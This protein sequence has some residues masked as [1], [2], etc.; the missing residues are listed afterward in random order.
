[1][2]DFINFNE[3]EVLEGAIEKYEAATNTKLY[4]GDERRIIL[5][6]FMYIASIIAA[7]SNFLANQYYS[8]T[9]VFPY[10]QYIGEDKDVPIL[11]AE[12]SLVTMRFTIAAALLF[13]IEI[14][15]GTRVTPDGVHFFVTL[16]TK[17]ILQGNLSVD[18]IAEATVVG[19]GHNGFTPG[20]I[21][22]LVDNISYI[23]SVTNTDTSSGGS[24]TE[25]IEAYRER[26]QLKPF[27]YNTAGSEDAYIYLTKSTDNTIGSVSVS[28]SD[29]S[30]LITILHKDGSI[31]SDPVVQRVS[32]ALSGKKVRPLSDKVTVQKASEIL[33]TI[34]F[35]YTISEENASNAEA[36]QG[37]VTEAV[38]SFI[39]YQKSKLGISVNPDILRNY[40][41]NAGAY[42]ITISG[43][44]FIF[45]NKQS[46]AHISGD[47]EI[48]YAGIY[49][50]AQ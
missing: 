30:V 48:N 2:Y 39:Q 16:T 9:A 21:N 44:A 40:I 7:K 46:V 24:E 11:E 31:P 45:V 19:S 17:V 22:T 50:E 35:S 28:N 27:G 12:K 25:D 1:M 37:K 8:K 49:D 10:L 4:A 6:S 14:N 26:I 36:I 41:S 3:S 23:S 33:Y 42:T 47:P 34:K 15:A 13:D 29:S 38:S 20:S 18:I 32:E 5:N 43:P